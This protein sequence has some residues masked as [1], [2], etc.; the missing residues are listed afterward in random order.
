ME[1]MQ[2]LESLAEKKPCKWADR[3]DKNADPVEFYRKNYSGVPRR[4][5]YERDSA[6]YQKLERDGLLDIVPNIKRKSKYGDDPAAY[7]EKHYQSMTAG[8]LIKVDPQLYNALFNR[9]LHGI[10]PHA[11]RERVH[12]DDPLG[13]YNEF[14]SDLTRGQLKCADPTLY[15]RLGKEGL[16]D[17]IPTRKEKI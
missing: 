13:Y 5:L 16:L 8:D 2:E 3:K 9:D 12:G 1:I 15:N 4:E 11:I 14:Y 7:Y 6:L 17:R 10:L